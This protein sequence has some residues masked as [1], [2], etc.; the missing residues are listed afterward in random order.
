[1]TLLAFA[2]NCGLPSGGCQCPDVACRAR[3]PRAQHRPQRQSG[4]AHA[5]VG[6]ERPA[7]LRTATASGAGTDSK[8][9]SPL[10]RQATLLAVILGMIAT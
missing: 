8:R 7:G 1:M 2:A 6:Q 3:S 9:I 4:K 10:V 5:D